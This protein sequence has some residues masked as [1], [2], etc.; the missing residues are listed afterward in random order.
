MINKFLPACPS[1]TPSADQGANRWKERRGPVIGAKRGSSVFNDD[2]GTTTKMTRR[3]RAAGIETRAANHTFIR[4]GIT[5]I[6]QDGGVLERASTLTSYSSA[7]N[8]L[9]YD[10]RSDNL[11]L[12]QVELI[13][14]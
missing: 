7:P 3:A 5:A 1:K 8:A 12:V 4:T 13:L 6:L 9:F 11:S 2:T 14:I 10:R